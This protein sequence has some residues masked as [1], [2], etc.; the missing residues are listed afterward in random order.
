MQI[1]VFMFLGMLQ[2]QDKEGHVRVGLSTDR[3]R[4]PIQQA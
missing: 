2:Y 1:Y 3:D 4:V